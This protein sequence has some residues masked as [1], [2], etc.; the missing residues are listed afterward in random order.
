MCTLL[1]LLPFARSA[2]RRTLSGNKIGDVPAERAL[3]ASLETLVVDN[4]EHPALEKAVCQPRGIDGERRQACNGGL[5][6]DR[7][8]CKSV[9][10]GC[11]ALW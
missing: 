5:V 1:T 2:T 6:V 8:G 4:E 3:L 9:Y 10:R 11:A 7:I